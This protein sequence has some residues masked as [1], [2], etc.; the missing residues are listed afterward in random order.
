MSELYALLPLLESIP[1]AEIVEPRLPVAVALQEAHELHTTLEHGD[2]RTRVLEIGLD[3]AIPA[4]LPTAIAAAR[5]AQSRWTVA[6]ARNLRQAHRARELQGQDIRR[7]LLAACRWNLRDVPDAQRTLATILDQARSTPAL[8][9]SL[10]DLATLIDRHRARFDHDASFD[11]TTQPLVARALAGALAHGLAF[12]RADHDPRAAKLLRDRAFTHLMG[13]VT[14]IRAAGRYAFRLEPRRA[15]R[16]SS[17]Y[18]R[19]RRRAARRSGGLDTPG[20]SST[21]PTPAPHGGGLDA[22]G[23]SSTPRTAAPQRGGQEA[24]SRYPRMICPMHSASFSGVQASTSIPTLRN[25]PAVLRLNAG[26]ASYPNAPSPTSRTP[27]CAM[28]RVTRTRSCSDPPS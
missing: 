7:E 25:L 19:K 27:D 3:P 1:D 13:I 23:G 26:L 5:Q 21:P 14:R 9:Q 20:G 11:A 28:S 10:H 18:R 24:R 15:A 17:A 4:A 22:P 12:L 6:R 8:V 2:T 16:F